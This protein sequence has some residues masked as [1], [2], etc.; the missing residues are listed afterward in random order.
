M[1]ILIVVKY[2][3]TEEQALLLTHMGC[4]SMQGHLHSQRIFYETLV[5]YY[6]KPLPT[7]TSAY[8]SIKM[9]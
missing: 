9:L 8:Q 5:A 7:K 3:E 6:P 4:Q 1:K 2:A